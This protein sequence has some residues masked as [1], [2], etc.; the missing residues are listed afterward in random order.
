MQKN[1]EEKGKEVIMK[2]NA[3]YYQKEKVKKF[4]RQRKNIARGTTDPGY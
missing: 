2:I 4:G 1:Y 3:K